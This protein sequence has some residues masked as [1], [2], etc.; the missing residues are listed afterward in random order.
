M[1]NS[2]FDNYSETFFDALHKGHDFDEIAK[3]YFPPHS[4]KHK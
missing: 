2:N 3:G 1:K 4:N